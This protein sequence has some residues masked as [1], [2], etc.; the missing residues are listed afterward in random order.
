MKNKEL[1]KK[2]HIGDTIY[3]L[4]EYCCTFSGI[5]EYTVTNISENS[6]NEFKCESD[7]SL[8]NINGPN[9]L[10]YYITASYSDM[11]PFLEHNINKKKEETMRHIIKYS[12]EI[13]QFE[14]DLELCKDIKNKE[15]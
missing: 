1:I 12:K 14:I 8:F 11:M 2:L 15:K 6:I 10:E 13:A 5:K 7:T 3:V 4:S 9:T